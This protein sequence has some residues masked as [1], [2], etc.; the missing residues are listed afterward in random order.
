MTGPDSAAQREQRALV[1]TL[2]AR[3]GAVTESILG[4]EGIGCTV[5]RDLDHL[6]AELD[7]GAGVVLLT[8]ESP[9]AASP[10]SLLARLG[11]QPHWSDLPL[12]ILIRPGGDSLAAAAAFRPL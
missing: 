1:L 10:A 8:E 12:L 3:D 11:S 7:E 2:T 5:C 4:P 9:T 6:C